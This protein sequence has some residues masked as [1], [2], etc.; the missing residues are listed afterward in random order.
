MNKYRNKTIL[1]TGAAGSIGSALV[2]KLVTLKSKKIV[3]LDINETALFYLGNEL[4]IVPILGNVRDM[5]TVDDAFCEHRPDIVIHTAAYKHVP[6]LEEFPQEAI[7]TNVAGTLVVAKKAQK[8][9]TKKFIFIST[10]KA[11]K[12]VSVMGRTKKA[13]ENI[14]LEFRG[15]TKFIIVRLGNVWGSQGSVLPIFKEQIRLGKP[16]T[17]THPDMERYFITMDK[18]VDF[19][20]NAREGISMPDM[21]EPV[22]IMDVARQLIAEEGIELPIIITGIRPGEKISE[23]L[24]E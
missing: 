13:C 8:Y 10:D 5:A 14:L 3:A 9:G 7:W 20:L 18:S 23:D 22:K 16:L 19:I 12:P 6:M 24:N 2:R 17:V 4:N 1:V 15:R 21:G 11:I